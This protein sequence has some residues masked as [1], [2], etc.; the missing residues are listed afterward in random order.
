MAVCDNCGKPVY[1]LDRTCANCGASV[2]QYA[3]SSYGDSRGRSRLN[4]DFSQSSSYDVLSTW[5]FVGS[6]VVMSLP[7]IG[8]IMTIVWASGGT[9]NLNRRN[10]ARGYLLIMGLGILLSIIMALALA[11]SGISLNQLYQLNNLIY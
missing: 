10:L 7:L 5:G 4:D 6:M 2:T 3:Q 8:F 11:S 1:R 9:A